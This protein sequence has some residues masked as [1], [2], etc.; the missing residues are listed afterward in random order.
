MSTLFLSAEETMYLLQKPRET[1]APW[2]RDRLGMGNLPN[3]VQLHV[4]GTSPELITRAWLEWTA[5]V[6]TYT[7]PDGG[8]TIIRHDQTG[9]AVHWES[10]QAV[11]RR[12][13]GYLQQAITIAGQ[14]DLV[15]QDLEDKIQ[16]V[17]VFARLRGHDVADWSE[18]WNP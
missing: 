5:P 10:A 9:Q 17:L 6:T 18:Q 7:S 1:L 14:D 11:K 2:L 12:R 3:N 8:E 4:E 13:L 16:Q 15:M